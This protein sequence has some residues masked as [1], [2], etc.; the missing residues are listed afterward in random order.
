[1]TLR[2]K[3][4][5]NR[6][7]YGRLFT[8]MI[9]VLIQNIITS[10][11][12]LLDNV[13]VGQVGTEP[14]SGVAIVNQLIFVFNLSIFG[15]LSGAGI[16]TAQFFGKSDPEGIRSTIRMKHYIGISAV[17]IA[18]AVLLLYGE[19]LIGLFIHQ[20]KESLD[21][22]MTL[23]HGMGY[24]RVMLFSLLPFAVMQVYASTLREC[25]ETMLPMKASVIA[26]FANL[27]GNYILIFG[28]FGAPELGVVGAAIS[29][30]FARWLE[31][32][33]VVVWTHRHTREHSYAKGIYSTL[34]IPKKLVIQMLITG[35]PL[36]LNELLWSSGKTFLNQC[37][38]VR[39]LEV[40][41]ALNI[42]TTISQ[43]FFCAF[44]AMGN[45]IA[46]M[47]GQLLGAGELERAVEEDRQLLFFSV[48]L[49]AAIGVFMAILAPY[50]P[51]LYNT[52]D[53]V[54][55]IA[56]KLIL[57]HSVMLPLH[58]FVHG[59]YFTLR[60]GGKTVITFFFD[61]GFMWA[62]S[63][64]AAFILSRFT[65]LDIIAMFAIVEAL[66]IIKALFGVYLL[67]KRSWV[68]RLV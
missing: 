24:M 2:E 41:S 11:V 1:M 23:T 66:E 53:V 62:F 15:G 44:F 55:E 57:I 8:I 14:M 50:I 39:G 56:T 17:V 49:S 5:G 26:V 28:K 21:L 42:A 59:S 63:V 51:R 9:P 30:V 65:G 40:V 64:L 19:E 36:L 61:C 29:T 52:T 18:T 34:K 22:Q 7:F 33:I 58:A 31:C 54:K 47:I 38:S 67:K 68:N 35:S 6:A 43:L 25:G 3:F 48:V 10:F 4:I 37:Y 45:T 12:S 27:I 20:G 13:M 46:V 32:L 16:F 60:S